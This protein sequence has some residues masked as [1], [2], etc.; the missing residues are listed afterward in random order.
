M[1]TSTIYNVPLSKCTVLEDR[2]QGNGFPF[3]PPEHT[4]QKEPSPPWENFLSLFANL[5]MH[6]CELR[7]A[8]SIEYRVTK[9]STL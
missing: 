9:T 1:Y 4:T 2:K 6:I 7:L 8:L 5:L 3:S